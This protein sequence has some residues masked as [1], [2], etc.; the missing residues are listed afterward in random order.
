MVILPAFFT[1]SPKTIPCWLFRAR[2][3]RS[4]G[5]DTSS[6]LMVTY[7]IPF[8]TSIT[9][10]S[11]SL[12]F[13]VRDSLAWDSEKTENARIDG[14][15]IIQ[16][17]FAISCTQRSKTPTGPAPAGHPPTEAAEAAAKTATPEASTKT[18]TPG[19]TTQKHS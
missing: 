15:I 19:P 3:R 5:T 1:S 7:S 16:I 14:I 9:T 12:D 6:A 10:W 4:S 13:S 18:T 2:A 8:S 17:V 11:V